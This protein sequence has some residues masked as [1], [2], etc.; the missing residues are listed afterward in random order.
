MHLVLKLL[1]RTMGPARFAVPIGNYQCASCIDERTSLSV[2]L[3]FHPPLTGVI[4]W[5]VR[6]VPPTWRGYPEQNG[7]LRD[8]AAAGPPHGHNNP[9]DAAVPGAGF[10]GRHTSVLPLSGDGSTLTSRKT[11]KNHRCGTSR[12]NYRL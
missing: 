1:F 3:G 5:I 9:G 4:R 7:Q 10:G 6:A 8:L 12:I 11:R 2:T